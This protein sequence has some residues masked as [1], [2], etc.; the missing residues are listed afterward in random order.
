MER[1]FVEIDNRT[2]K[3]V[4]IEVFENEVVLGA[5]CRNHAPIGGKTQDLQNILHK[6][7]YLYESED[8]YPLFCHP[9]SG[10]I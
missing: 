7:R 10:N 9:G 1:H 5:G 4:F 3:H 8:L 2:S 6:I